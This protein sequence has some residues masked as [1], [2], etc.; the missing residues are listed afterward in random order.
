M[1]LQLVSSRHRLSAATDMNPITACNNGYTPCGTNGNAG[2]IAPGQICPSGR[3]RRRS[4]IRACPAELSI[5]AVPG[6]KKY[7][8]AFE[9]VDTRSDLES[10]GACAFPLPGGRRGE[11]C[12]AVE[13]VAG[14]KVS[15]AP[16]NEAESAG[17]DSDL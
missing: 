2:C 13:G 1:H 3:T 17:S 5:C 4:E 14:V 6:A 12:T 15:F 10:C 16:G 11:D 9:C 8:D 7:S